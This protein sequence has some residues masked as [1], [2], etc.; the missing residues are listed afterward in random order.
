MGV[1]TAGAS[2]KLTL[3]KKPGEQ[4]SIGFVRGGQKGTATVTLEAQP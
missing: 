4:V 1:P 2:V 3:T